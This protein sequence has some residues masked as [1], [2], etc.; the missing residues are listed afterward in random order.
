MTE[1]EFW[2]TL[3]GWGLTGKRRV[4]PRTF[5][6]LDRDGDVCNVPDPTGMTDAERNAALVLIKQL[7]V[8][9]DS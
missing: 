6:M 2:G 3:K 5:A 4:T 1:A 8:R 7:H 9:M